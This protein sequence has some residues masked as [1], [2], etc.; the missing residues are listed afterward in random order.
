MYVVCL[1]NYVQKCFWQPMISL[2]L[3]LGSCVLHQTWYFVCECACVRV[4]MCKC[5]QL[6]TLRTK[7]AINEFVSALVVRHHCQEPSVRDGVVFLVIANVSLVKT[8][9]TR[10]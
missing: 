3:C 10:A 4:F 9:I 1:C 5:M 2:G 6:S 7:V 8:G